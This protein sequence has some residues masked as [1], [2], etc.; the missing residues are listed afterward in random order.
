[1]TGITCTTWLRLASS[2]TT[3]P[4]RRWI[5]ICVDTTSEST[6]RPSSTT[7]AAVSS[8]LVSMPRTFTG[9]SFS[10]GSRSGAQARQERPHPFDVPPQ[11]LE[12]QVALEARRPRLPPDGL[13]ERQP[14]VADLGVE[15]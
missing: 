12:R 15:R 1:M 7:A 6:R 2:G 8:Q 13:A 4:Q 3:P 14:A 10:P 11:R 9:G 5:S